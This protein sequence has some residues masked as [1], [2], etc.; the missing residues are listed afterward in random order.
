[1]AS[2][3]AWIACTW[4]LPL[5]VY[6]QSVTPGDLDRA[7]RQSEQLLREQ[8][9][10]QEASQ[11]ERDRQRQQPAGEALPA[12]P[13]TPN[14]A[15]STS[16]CVDVHALELVGARRLAPE[17][18][19]Q[20]D[21]DV[22]GHCIG[23]PELNAL[24]RRITEAYVSQGYVT[25]RA[26]VPPQ[27]AEGGKLTIVVVEGSVE[28][29]GVEPKGSA[30]VATA[31][32]EV[33]GQVFNLRDA[34]QG[35]D[36]LNRL[37]SNNAR[38]DIRPG[39]TPGSSELVVLNS[40][41]RRVAGSLASDNTGS[42]ATG[43]RQGALTLLA[44]NPL[45]LNDGLI[46]TH[47]RSLD[48][49]PG[50]AMSRATTVSYSIPY[51]W[52]TGT[53]MYTE[54]AY[55][56]LVQGITQDFVTSGTSRNATVRFDRVAYRD[57]NIKLTLYGDLARRDSQNFV[58]DQ[59]IGAS[60]RV[61]TML[62][63]TANLSVAHGQALWSFDAGLS[64][65][66]PWLGGLDDAGD[67]TGDAPRARFL[68]LTADAGVSRTFAPFGVRTQLSSTLA[69]QWSNDV[70]FPSEQIAIA[71]PFAVRG[72]R[73]SRLFGDRG[74]TWRNELGFPFAL[75]VGASSPLHVRP[76]VGGDFG[77]VWAHN[78]LRGAHLSG[79]AAGVNLA[80]AP[81]SLQ[82]SWSGATARSAAVPSDHL[83]FARLAASF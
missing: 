26:Y 14:E 47:S 52:W 17:Q 61:L 21:R 1:V 80:L 53:L 64:H 10:R 40:P 8:Q 31:F 82:L 13:A 55:A 9:Q 58:A 44:D 63:L 60:S 33:R 81:I 28:R 67:R 11:R 72:Y 68:K 4:G 30:S 62:D 6:A 19:R 56:S 46:V 2:I 3:S 83:F 34:E 48:A 42:A 66:V 7:A 59:L 41:S 24:L 39:S 23:V 54:A 77:K 25:S 57:Q 69:A 22:V 79:I 78:G 38:L 16:Q 50:P 73:D 29:I 32:P 75:G 49:P 70:L 15:P 12:P 20:F 43:E 74:F 71:G 35:I 27:N 76:F 37:S 5:T 51:G 18:V 36:Q 45:G 65:G